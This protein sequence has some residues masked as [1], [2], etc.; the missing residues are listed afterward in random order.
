MGAARRRSLLGYAVLRLRPYCRRLVGRL[1]RAGARWVA[2]TLRYNPWRRGDD[3]TRT[4][5]GAVSGIERRTRFSSHRSLDD[6]L[7][8]GDGAVGFVRSGICGSLRSCG[9]RVP[10]LGAIECGP[11]ADTVSSRAG[12]K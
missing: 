5:R 3:G 8:D 11:G 7:I 12:H 4:Y 6:G 9:T 10:S 1:V 2:V